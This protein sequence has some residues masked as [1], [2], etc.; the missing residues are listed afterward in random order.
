MFDSGVLTPEVV[1][2]MYLSR[3][4]A[5]DRAVVAESA[6]W[7]DNRNPD[8][9]AYTRDDWLLE[10]GRLMTEFFP[11]RTRIL[12]NQLRE[13]KLYPEL[14]APVFSKSGGAVENGFNLKIEN[15]S[16][17]GE[18]FYTINGKDPRSFAQP[19]RKMPLKEENI[20][21]EDELFSS[22]TRLDLVIDRPPQPHNL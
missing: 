3:L 14:D 21:L 18:I 11:E 15:P 17:R 22:T 16:N 7:G 5:I 19:Q 13:D 10:K 1:S 2:T 6:R 20:V 9:S 12:L 8:N 4:D